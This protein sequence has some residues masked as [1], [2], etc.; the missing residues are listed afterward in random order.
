MDIIFLNNLRI[1]ARIGIHDWER[2]VKQ[3]VV[4]DL[5][6]GADVARAAAADEIEDTLSY[7]DVAK[8]VIEFVGASEFRL[9]ETLAEQIAN[10]LRDEFGV[11]W[12]K[13]RVNKRGAVRGAG[14][15]GVAIERGART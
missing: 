4:L 13:V 9:V 12:M 14:D 15:V 8:R 5:E 3:T 7:R 2:Q 10:L 1:P 6:M 11:P